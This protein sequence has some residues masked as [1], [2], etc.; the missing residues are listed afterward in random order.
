MHQSK[1]VMLSKFRSVEWI[2]IWKSSSLYSQL[3]PCQTKGPTLFS[4]S[5]ARDLKYCKLVY[6]KV[7]TQHNIDMPLIIDNIYNKEKVFKIIPNTSPSPT[8]AK[9]LVLIFNPVLSQ[10]P[11]VSL[12]LGHA[13]L[14]CLLQC[15]G[16]R[17]LCWFR[18]RIKI[19]KK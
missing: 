2:A 16:P 17:I 11:W 3:S 14:K 6:F 10:S 4:R 7:T 18:E 12:R 1:N 9:Q 19:I 15:L 13:H 5:A 8:K